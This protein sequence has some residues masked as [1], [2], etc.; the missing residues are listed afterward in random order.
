MAP[1]IGVLEWNDTGF[2]GRTHWGDEEGMSPAV[3]M[4]SWSLWSS[5]WRWMRSRPRADGS[6][7]KAGQG[8]VTL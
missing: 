5:A 2:L 6:G 8:L 4:N 7:L 3:S 1:I